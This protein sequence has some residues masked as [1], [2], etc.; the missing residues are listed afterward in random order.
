MGF[1]RDRFSLNL[2]LMKLSSQ[3]PSLAWD[4]PMLCLCH[5]VLFFL[6]L[7]RLNNLQ[8]PQNL[9]LPPSLDPHCSFLSCLP[10]LVSLIFPTAFL[11]CLPLLQ[12]PSH[13]GACTVL[14]LS[15]FLEHCSTMSPQST[16]SS[17]RPPSHVSS[18]G[19]SSP[20]RPSLTVTWNLSTRR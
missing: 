13:S 15:V 18:V 16:S 8:V 9:D 10:A 12:G 17:Q 5:F 14:L 2:I 7:P 3:G 11:F 1:Y 19:N 4:L 6:R 20:P